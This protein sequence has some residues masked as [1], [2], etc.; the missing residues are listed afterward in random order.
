VFEH[1]TDSVET[2]DVDLLQFTT[3]SLP[4]V[5][6][7]TLGS[8]VDASAAHRNHVLVIQSNIGGFARNLLPT[9]LDGSAVNILCSVDS[10]NVTTIV[11]C[12]I[13]HVRAAH[14]HPLT[15]WPRSLAP[16]LATVVHTH[17]QGI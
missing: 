8:E 16:V 9:A 2:I 10:T 15:A 5:S 13:N 7:N 14:V 1:A 6:T 4:A 17:H 3:K 12:E 11:D